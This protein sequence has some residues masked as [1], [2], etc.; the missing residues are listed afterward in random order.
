MDSAG[1]GQQCDVRSIVH[2]DATICGSESQYRF[3][4]TQEL[5]GAGILISNLNQ[6]RSSIKQ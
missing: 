3:D 1:S 4:L 5:T 6:P 2:D